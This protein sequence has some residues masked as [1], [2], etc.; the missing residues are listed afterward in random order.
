VAANLCCENGP[1]ELGNGRNVTEA[2]EGMAGDS[3]LSRRLLYP[4]SQYSNWR[5]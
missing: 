1:M 5:W 4:G 3:D 2:D